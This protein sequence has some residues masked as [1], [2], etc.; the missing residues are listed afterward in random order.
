MTIFLSFWKKTTNFQ[1]QVQLTK[2]F[3][4]DGQILSHNHIY[5][6]LSKNT[7]YMDHVENSTRSHLACAME[8]AALV[9]QNHFKIKPH[10]QRMVIH[11]I[12]DLMMVDHMW[13]GNVTGYP[14]V[15]QSNPCPYP[16]KPI[17]ASTGTG[18]C[19]YG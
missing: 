3:G 18:F 8:N 4:Q 9:F 19:G 5:L 2:S 14:G 1:H 7:C 17:P 15:F 11:Y 16:S 12:I 10:F 13:L 6:K